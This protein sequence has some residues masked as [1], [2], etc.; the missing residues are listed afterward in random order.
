MVGG[1]I[2][3]RQTARALA[4]AALFSTPFL[5]LTD[6]TLLFASSTV[7]LLGAL[8]LFHEPLDLAYAGYM[9]LVGVLWEYTGVLSGQW[10]YP[11]SP[12]LGVP[13]WFAPMF[14]GIGLFARRLV[15]PF[16]TDDASERVW[17]VDPHVSI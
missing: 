8:I 16:L 5:L 15:L 2:P 11:A 7:L 4:L 6:P 9:I 17:R 14:G 10:I 3:P 13:L 12:L 1:P